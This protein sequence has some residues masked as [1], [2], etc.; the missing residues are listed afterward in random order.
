MLLGSMAAGLVLGVTLGATTLRAQ[1]GKG[2]GLAVA[3]SDRN[4]GLPSDT[5][6]KSQN[7]A[8]GDL[9]VIFKRAVGFQKT[10]NLEQAASEYQRILEM[11]PEMPE[12][13]NN[14][15]LILQALGDSVSAR[16]KYE[17]ALRIEPEY[18]TALNNLASLL[19]GESEYSR[20]RDLWLR[21][22]AKNPL[23]SELHFNLAL[24]YLKTGEPDKS[25]KS[26]RK[27]L[28]LNPQHAAA[29]YVLGGILQ[30]QGNYEGAL[31][32]YMGYLESK[33]DP[34]VEARNYVQHQIAELKAYLGIIND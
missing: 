9:T 33:P 21:A 29:H 6:T 7:I 17:A 23:D 12:V 16:K 1:V 19:Y 2:T 10:G 5:P 15:G 4:S 26:L 32:A 8:P 22:I 20:A 27:A 30:E 31:R 11:R 28:T 34:G 18:D 25:I 24:N 3:V 14:L 13:L